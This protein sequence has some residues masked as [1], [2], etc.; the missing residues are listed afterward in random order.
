M[1]LII[2]WGVGISSMD[3]IYT[4]FF[5][6]HGPIAY[7]LS[8]LIELIGGRSF[9]HFRIIFSLL[10]FGFLVWSYLY[11]RRGFGKDRSFFYLIFIGIISLAGNYYWLHMLLADTLSAYFFAP[12]VTILLLVNFSNCFTKWLIHRCY[13]NPYIT[14]LSLLPHL[15]L[16]SNY[17]LCIFFLSLFQV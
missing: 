5:T 3:F 16:S 14:Y 9:V 12:V 1:S 17:Y 4:S 8:G 11:I 2:L 10:I 6:H 15:S 13:F 7:F